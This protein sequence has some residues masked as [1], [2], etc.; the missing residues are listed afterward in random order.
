MRNAPKKCTVLDLWALPLG[1]WPWV[2]SSPVN[3]SQEPSCIIVR[4]S[5][6]MPFRCLECSS[7]SPQRPTKSLRLRPR[8]IDFRSC[9]QTP[10]SPPHLAYRYRFP[11]W[12]PNLLSLLHSPY[13]AYFKQEKEIYKF[14]LVT[15]L[16]ILHPEVSHP[17]CLLVLLVSA[18]GILAYCSL[19][20]HSYL[21]LGCFHIVFL[22]SLPLATSLACY[23]ALVEAKCLPKLPCN[24]SFSW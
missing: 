6:S 15:S 20:C 9:L 3:Q 23:R 2:N 10:T 22:L 19:G 11:F 4:T 14:C 8:A 1:W 5:S 7:I 17:P 18:L 21:P 12:T 24:P 16:K 13:L